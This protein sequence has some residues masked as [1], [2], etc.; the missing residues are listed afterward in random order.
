[1]KGSTTIGVAVVIVLFAGL[2][3]RPASRAQNNA[4]PV[5]QVALAR[6]AFG[7]N[8]AQV[9]AEFIG[10]LIFLPVRVNQGQPSLF[11]IDSTAPFT[12]AD[13]QRAAELSIV[14][15]RGP[16]LNL[17]GVDISLPS[18]G[19]IANNDFAARVGRAYEGTIGNDV[20]A[21]VVLEIDYSR[22]TMRIYDP[23]AFR[24]TGA[25]K[26]FPLAFRDGM[27][28]VKAKFD[29]NGHKSGEV[30]FV[31]N[32]ATSASLVIS[33]KFAQQHHLFSSHMKTISVGPG[34]LGL[35]GNAVVARI[36]SFQ[37]GPYQIDQP[38]ATFAQGKLP[39]GD[40]KE[41]AGEIGGGML[42]RF[43]V[44]FDYVRQQV[45]FD[46]NGDIRSDD[47]EDMSGMSIAA[48]GPDLKAFTVTQVRPGTPAS[49]A[50][51]QTGD[52]IA[53]VD[54]EAAAD[55]T[56]TA[57]RGLFQQVGHKYKLTIERNGKPLTIN[58]QMR[59]LL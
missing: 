35:G 5:Q 44:T 29:V 23:A 19:T 46:P 14:D 40:D 3:F 36:E 17:S 47:R 11:Q 15:L 45:I 55:M 54:E 20:F 13:P 30:F 10:N 21:G 37:I 43:N 22:Q 9:P 39:G 18:L 58:L 57:L 12:S 53:G 49:A 31:L 8:V 28:V 27:P 59:R 51:V 7:G 32:T 52:V 1:M 26:T 41:I 38:L 2:A 42:R 4:A 34:E 33:D 25:G 56:V 48:S 6:F 24:Y 16:V 50:G